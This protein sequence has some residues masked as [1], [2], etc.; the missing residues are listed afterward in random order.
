MNLFVC[1]YMDMFICVCK[2]LYCGA[3]YSLFIYS[4]I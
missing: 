4:D 3:Y 1:G 2:Y